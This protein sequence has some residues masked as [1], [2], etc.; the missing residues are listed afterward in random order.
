MSDTFDSDRAE[1]PDETEPEESGSSGGTGA[2]GGAGRGRLAS[3]ST[4]R[5]TGAGGGGARALRR[6]GPI[7]AAVVV[8]VAAVAIF[9][10]GGD[11][12][13]D[14]GDAAGLDVDSDALAEAG[15]ITFQRAEDEGLDDVD[16][17]DHCDPETGRIELPTTLA[18]QCV[19][20]FDGDNGGATSQ[21]VTDDEILVV[22]Y[23]TNPEL[24]PLASSIASGG[25]AD[26]DPALTEEALDN[27][28]RLYN[29]V[30]ETYG[31][32][33]RVER[34]IGSGASDDVEAAKADAIAIADMEPFAVI[35]G[36]GQATGPFATE[37]AK[38]GIVCG[39]NCTLSEPES[40]LEDNLPYMW[41][42]GPTPDQAA[43]LTAE[44]AGKLIG[45][46]KAEL[47]G[48]DA[49]RAED[50]VYAL[51]HY[52]T[53]SGDHQQIFEAL[54]DG[55]A[56]NGIDLA[57]DIRFELD[58]AT[59]QED[60]RTMVAPLTKE[61]TAQD[62]HP[63]WI[64]G[65]TVLGDSTFFARM[66]DGEQ[67]QNGFGMSLIAGRGT[68]DTNESVFIYEWAFGEEPP[69]NTVTVSEPPLRTIFTG[70]HLAGPDLTPESFRDGLYRYLPSGGTPTNPQ[71]S[72]GDHGFWPDTDLGG[73][74]DM[75]LIWW[76]PDVQGP[77]EID[78]EG[79]G[80]YRYAN[81]GERYTLGNLPSS[82][83]EAGLFD[84]DS[85]VTLYEELPEEDVPPDYPPPE[86]D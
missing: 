26:T 62:Y 65:P 9:G 25:G 54:R 74:D 61:A 76:D 22:S 75:T 5:G 41:A 15:P 30:Y 64:M 6:Y 2:T 40:I 34:F 17:G 44:M 21:G 29:E 72:R 18:A 68:P 20:A 70:I 58:L 7:A 33:V 36:P 55:L 59:A 37:L 48:D 14:D 10:G 73:I 67:W 78:N 69:A 56:E 42:P 12:D 52:D 80:M 23:A 16:F 27:Y 35:G 8:V 84:V 32:T 46:G 86:L 19:E 4:Q 66:M 45:P 82:V 57:T 60:A 53:P 83:E 63:E 79:E 38:E 71:V 28:A 13:D 24:D 43:L 3:R 11:D 39:P 31:R 49:T 85:S 50:R 1:E 47:A 81:G 77:D 51:L